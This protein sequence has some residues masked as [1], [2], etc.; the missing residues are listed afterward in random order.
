MLVCGKDSGAYSTFRFENAAL[1]LNFPH[2]VSHHRPEYLLWG[3]T[4][5]ATLKYLRVAPL[6][7]FAFRFRCPALKVDTP[8]CL[9]YIVRK[10][11]IDRAM[12]HEAIRRIPLS[13]RLSRRPGRLRRFLPGYCRSRNDSE[14]E[15]QMSN[16]YICII[17]IYIYVYVCTYLLSR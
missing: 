3:G 15:D 13:R 9:R 17:Y 10:W 12:R 16:T 4:L 2:Y 11:A 6:V 5:K 7:H 1:N 14:S 8:A